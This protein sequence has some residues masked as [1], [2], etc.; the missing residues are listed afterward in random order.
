MSQPAF[1]ALLNAGAAT[2]LVLGWMAIRGVGL[3][4]DEALHKRF[5]ISA[6]VVSSVFLASYLDYHYSVGHVEFWGDGWIRTLYLWVL[7]PHIILATVMVPMII[8][9][10]VHAARGSLD[11]HKRL[12][13]WTLPIWLYVSVTGVVVYV[14]QYR[15]GP[16]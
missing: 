4:R 15:L 16:D 8:V 5:M 3:Q 1:H 12:A 2:L 9:L 14:M 11:R 6:L 13:R 7:V 10:V